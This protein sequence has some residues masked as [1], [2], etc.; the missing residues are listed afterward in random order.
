MEKYPGEGLAST[1]ARGPWRTFEGGGAG[2]GRQAGRSGL[3]LE[4]EGTREVKWQRPQNSR[5][6][7]R[8]P[9]VGSR[10][11]PDHPA[12]VGG[13]HRPYSHVNWSFKT[14]TDF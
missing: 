4:A 3:N 5:R 1:K 9:A 2:A 8:V 7:L 11:L 14:R 12:A 10:G 6:A 13:A